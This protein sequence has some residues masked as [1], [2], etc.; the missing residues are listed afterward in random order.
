M[1]APQEFFDVTKRIHNW[2]HGN[3]GDGG[4]LDHEAREIYAEAVSGTLCEIAER[5]RPEMSRSST[6]RSRPA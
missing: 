2:L 6:I 3:V 5:V 1:E 4:A